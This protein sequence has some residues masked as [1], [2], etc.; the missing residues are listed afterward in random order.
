[1]FYRRLEEEWGLFLSR[2]QTLLAEQCATPIQ[3]KEYLHHGIRGHALHFYYAHVVDKGET[4][5]G[6]IQRLF[7]ETLS[8]ADKM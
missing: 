8:A 7:N 1:M 5:W 6:P 4:N 3:R 2:Y